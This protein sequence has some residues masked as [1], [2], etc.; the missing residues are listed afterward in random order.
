[1]RAIL[2]KNK[3][4]KEFD[5]VCFVIITI[6]RTFFIRRVLLKTHLRKNISRTK[7]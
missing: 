2:L 4:R 3:L 5:C 7:E 1:M 6:I